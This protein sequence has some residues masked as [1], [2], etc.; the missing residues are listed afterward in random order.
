MV[1]V[2]QSDVAAAGIE[3]EVCA[4]AVAP[5]TTEATRRTT[6]FTCFLRMCVTS[7]LK[8]Y[9]KSN[10]ASPAEVD[11]RCDADVE[12]HFQFVRL[13]KPLPSSATVYS[14]MGRA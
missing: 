7:F 12:K 11:R 6:I 2:L 10:I 14:L 1:L 9:L 3:G 13:A 5:R 4:M 8:K